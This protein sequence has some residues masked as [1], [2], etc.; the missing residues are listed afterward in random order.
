[1]F[2]RAV[3][4]TV[5][6]AVAFVEMDEEE[7]RIVL[8]KVLADQI[9][10]DRVVFAMLL[11][12]AEVVLDDPEVDGIPVDDRREGRVGAIFANNSENGREN[13]V[14]RIGTLRHVPVDQPVI[15]RRD[16]V[17]HRAP[18]FG[19]DRRIGGQRLVCY[20]AVLHDAA[21]IGHIGVL[22][23][24][25]RAVDANNHDAS[26]AARVFLLSRLW[27]RGKERGRKERDRENE[28]QSQEGTQASFSFNICQ[29]NRRLIRTRRKPPAQSSR[30]MV[31]FLSPLAGI[32]TISGVLIGSLYFDGTR[33][34][35]LIL[36]LSKTTSSPLSRS[37]FS[38]SSRG[39]PLM[40]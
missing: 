13:T 8:F 32:S 38:Y 5:P 34:S 27:R 29:T 3:A 1:M 16:P 24:R 20:G 39:L 4:E 35:V 31:M 37:S 2:L 9:G 6:G 22:E 23:E 36:F 18:T 17:E 28:R 26:D 25:A 15:L 11:D 19:A 14:F 40:V 7:R 21:E 33:S 12:D 10:Y 30:V